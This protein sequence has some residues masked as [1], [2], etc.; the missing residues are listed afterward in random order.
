MFQILAD[1]WQLFLIGQYPH[2]PLGGL[3]V[4]LILSLLG[5]GLAF[6]VSILLALARISPMAV[7]RMPA[8]V[9]VYV[10]RGIP[11]LM[12]IFWTYFFLPL[13]IGRTITGFTTMLCTLVIYQSA[14]LSEV[15][16]AGIEAL[17][18]GQIEAS[19]ALG[20]SYF[21]T[22]R[23]VIL[24]QALYNMTPSM[25]SQFVST[26]K[27]TSLGYVIN[28]PEMTF[29]AN[30]V[31]NQLLTKPLPVFMI[32]ALTYFIVCFSFTQFADYLE[33]RITHK[34]RGGKR[35]A[36]AVPNIDKLPQISMAGS[37]EEQA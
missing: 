2:G 12:V 27:E 19:R 31:N 3:S 32:L 8:T 22:I 16:R 5:L 25:V 23:H 17:P 6:P 10:V 20:L 29:A 24:P 21:K 13:L 14:Y 9:L 28:V 34:R 35:V 18:R 15:I 4:T 30:Q 36:N 1:N 37:S 7:F 26:I 11:L 33:R